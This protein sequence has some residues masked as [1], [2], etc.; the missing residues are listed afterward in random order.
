MFLCLLFLIPGLCVHAQSDGNGDD[1]AQPEILV[2][3]FSGGGT[4]E[5]KL[6]TKPEITFSADKLKVTSEAV[7]TEYDRT[8]VTEFVFTSGTS[9]VG[10]ASAGKLTLT[11]TDNESVS[12]TGT[13]ASVAE[14]YSTGGNLLSRQSVSGGSVTVSLQGYAPGVFILKLGNEQTFKII[15]K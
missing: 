1:E 14:L 9:S 8:E 4:A 11:Y 10:N 15:K 12:V 13:K 3:K 6:S 7:E 2:L 5:F